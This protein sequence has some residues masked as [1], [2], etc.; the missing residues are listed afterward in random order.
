MS[1]FDLF[2]VVIDHKDQ[3]TDRAI[4][5]HIVSLH[6]HGSIAKTEVRG[7]IVRLDHRPRQPPSA[8]DASP[9]PTFA[10]FRE[11]L[12]RFAPSG[13]ALPP[14]TAAVIH[15]LHHAGCPNRPCP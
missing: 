9:P 11:L 15:P 1:R 7:A 3:V 4:A 13:D 6:Q 10:R 8:S 2:F 14:F 5:N 12:P